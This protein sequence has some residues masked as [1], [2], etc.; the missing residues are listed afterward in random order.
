MADT[1]LDTR[2]LAREQEQHMVEATNASFNMLKPVMQLNTAAWRF[3][4]DSFNSWINNCEKTCDSVMTMIDQQTQNLT[5]NKQQ[6]RS[7]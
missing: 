5:S 1:T 7:G 4:A 3:Y 6:Q 2:R